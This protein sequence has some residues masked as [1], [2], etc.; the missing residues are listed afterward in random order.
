M[1]SH[2]K[3]SQCLHWFSGTT[4]FDWYLHARQNS[5]PKNIFDS[6]IQS[7]FVAK[8]SWKCGNGLMSS[9]RYVAL[10]FGDRYSAKRDNPSKKK[11]QNEFFLCWYHPFRSLQVANQQA[12]ST[13]LKQRRIRWNYFQQVLGRCPAEMGWLRF[14]RH[15]EIRSCKVLRLY[16]RQYFNISLSNWLFDCYW[17]G[18]QY[19][20]RLWKLVPRKQNSHSAGHEQNYEG[21]SCHLR[22]ER[23]SQKRIAVVLIRAYRAIP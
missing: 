6:N 4:W 7:P 17:Y 9:F 10:K 2:Y 15:R 16:Y 12:L 20:F 19:A 5:D 22:S 3:Q 14:S 1:V 23:K 18:L 8:D 11:L 21:K 13:P